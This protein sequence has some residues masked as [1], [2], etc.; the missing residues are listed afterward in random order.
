[1]YKTIAQ[2]PHYSPLLTPKYENFKY[3][4]T[5]YNIQKTDTFLGHETIVAYCS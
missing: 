5:H 4:Y 2:I 1:M 3:I